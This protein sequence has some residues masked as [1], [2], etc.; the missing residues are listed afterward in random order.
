MHDSLK[1]SSAKAAAVISAHWFVDGPDVAGY[2]AF[3]ALVFED[4]GRGS[5]GFVLAISE[6]GAIGCDRHLLS[7]CTS[8]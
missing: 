1:D 2:C 5:A 8:C 3:V 4:R 6:A 7:L